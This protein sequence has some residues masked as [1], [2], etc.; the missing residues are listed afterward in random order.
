MSFLKSMKKSVAVAFALVF[1]TLCAPSA[2]AEPGMWTLDHLPKVAM[3]K[4]LGWSPSADWTQKAMLGAARLAGG[5]SASFVSKDG[6]VLTN[7]HCAAQC[8]EEISDA[9]H[10][11]LKDGFLAKSRAQERSCPAMEVNRLEKITDVT[12]KVKGATQNLSGTEFQKAKNAV[13]ANLTAECAA[14]EKEK[15]RCD[16]VSLYHGGQYKLYQYHRFQDVRLVFA[17]EQA[18]AFFGGDPDNFN[19]PRFDLDMA[20]VRVYEGGQPAAVTQFFPLNAKGP[21]AGE[22]VMT[23]GHPGST[24]RELTV[25]Q[26]QARRDSLALNTLPR[27]SQMRGMLIEFGELGEEQK[28]IATESL[29]G[30]ENSYKALHGQLE[31]LLTPGL[32]ERKATEEAELQRFVAQNPAL[33]KEVGD[34]WQ[35]IAKAEKLAKNIRPIYSQFEGAAAF[36]SRYFSMARAL[37]RGAVER[38]KPNAE[39]LPEYNES[40][41]PQLQARLFSEAP[42]YPEFENLLLTFS[43]TKAR[44]VLGADD[45]HIKQ[46]L[47]NE[48]PANMAKD[49]MAR[50]QLGDIQVRHAL[51]DGGLSAVMQSQDP[52]IQ[53]ALKVDPIA[54]ALRTRYE[55][56]VDSVVTKNSEKIAKARFALWGDRQAPDATFTLRL[57]YGR[58]KGW[59]EGGRAIAPFTTLGGAYTRAT[60]AEPF[61]LTDAWLAAKDRLNLATPFNFVSTNDIIGGNSGSPVLNRQGELVGLVFDGNLPSLGGAYWFDAAVNRAVAVDSAAIIETMNQI[62]GAQDLTRE[63][64]GQ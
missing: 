2:H 40:A 29:F 19:F 4:D 54:R 8:I 50:T 23:V 42:I 58:V 46:I 56:E 11:Y 41:L 25:A 33:K 35:Q 57:S 36:Q 18:M 49:L 63:M 62:Y 31:A 38:A 22:P 55:K 37:V 9:S 17:P 24:Q 15:I 3:E 47:G 13:E 10:N 27:L 6:L 21:Q 45:E 34:A 39:R 60:G 1:G 59:Q 30:V 52:F 12:D 7:H 20:M 61:K 14:K 32:L 28:R 5:C 26:L 48:S 16:V 44:E 51:W 53:L 43:L 64:L